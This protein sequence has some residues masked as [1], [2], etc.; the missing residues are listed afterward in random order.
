MTSRLLRKHQI[1]PWSMLQRIN[2]EPASSGLARWLRDTGLAGLAIITLA[3]GA[4]AGDQTGRARISPDAAESPVA[5]SGKAR[6][7][8]DASQTSDSVSG[9]AQLDSNSQEKATDVSGITRFVS[10]APR[11]PTRVAGRARLDSA[12]AKSPAANAG[13]AKQP[14]E[15]WVRSKNRVSVSPATLSRILPPNELPPENL[16]PS[17]RTTDSAVR[18]AGGTLAASDESGAEVPS[19]DLP[20][21]EVAAAENPIGQQPTDNAQAAELFPEDLA[22]SEIQSRDTVT[23]RAPTIELP[24]ERTSDA[25]AMPQDVTLNAAAATQNNAAVDE[26]A[27]RTHYSGQVHETFAT[28]HRRRMDY[29]MNGGSPGPIS[30]V[31]EWWHEHSEQYVSNNRHLAVV[32]GEWWLEHSQNYAGRNRHLVEASR[33]SANQFM[34][35]HT[36]P[37]YTVPEVDFYDSNPIALSAPSAQPP[38][39]DPVPE[40]GGELTGTS[41]LK[42]DIRTIKPTLSYALKGIDRNQLPD[43]FDQRIDNG[44]Y[45]ARQTSPTVLQWAPTNLWH[46][47]LYFEDPSLERYGHSYHPLVQPFAST[48]RFATQLV[49]LPYQMT[50]HPVHSKEYALGYYRPGECAPKKF[51]QIPFNE[52]AT[53][54]QVATIAGLILIFP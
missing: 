28:A 12:E 48:G 16:F 53:L 35:E 4:L 29:V 8:P 23:G 34:I 21:K 27:T 14:Q 50:L 43:D 41:R 25:A 47:P 26:P 3:S 24:E 31:G 54:M 33:N 44:E 7:A 22:A 6:L 46:Y 36:L 52:E 13:T 38:L 40:E 17:A 49:G 15:G 19:R 45:V 2:S 39:E 10:E 9:K 5:V 11:S 37:E 51:Y 20:V 1:T 42:T 32:S 30:S 18:A